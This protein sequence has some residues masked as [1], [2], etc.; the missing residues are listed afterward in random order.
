MEDLKEGEKYNIEWVDG[1]YKTN[2]VFEKKHRGFLIFIDENK[3]KVI[4]RPNSI[5]SLSLL[6][7]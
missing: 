5:K 7:D 1:D 4:C 3:M 6:K 2:C